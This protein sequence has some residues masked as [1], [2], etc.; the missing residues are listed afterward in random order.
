MMMV[1]MM[2]MMCDIVVIGD[3]NGGFG[4]QIHQEVIWTHRKRP[5]NGRLQVDDGSNMC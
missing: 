5:R 3:R 2:M 1:M 4:I